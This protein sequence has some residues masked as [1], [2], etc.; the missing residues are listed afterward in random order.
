ME[1]QKFVEDIIKVIIGCYNKWLIEVAYLGYRFF[2]CKFAIGAATLNAVPL[3]TH[4]GTP[5]EKPVHLLNITATVKSENHSKCHIS[6]ALGFAV[7]YD[8]VPQCQKFILLCRVRSNIN[9]GIIRQKT[10]GRV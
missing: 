6:L 7:R 3:V 2:K 9:H 8:S 1:F 4:K 10:T 5:S